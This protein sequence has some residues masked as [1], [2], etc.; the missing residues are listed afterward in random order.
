V[1]VKLKQRVSVTTSTACPS[2]QQIAAF[3]DGVLAG[4]ERDALQRHLDECPACFDLVATLAVHA[5]ADAARP[6]VDPRLRDAVVR[7]QQTPSKTALRLLPGLSAA[8]AI[9]L[10]AVWWIGPDGSRPAPSQPTAPAASDANPRATTRSADTEG[11]VT[12]QEPRDGAEIQGAQIVRWLGPPDATFYEIQITTIAGDVVLN[13][14][15][16][17]TEHEVRIELPPGG[18]PI[19]YLWVAAYLPEGRRITSNV[20]KL[21]LSPK[22]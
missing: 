13:R 9:L 11:P 5:D 17:G 20:V 15:V 22:R 12:V 10:A 2:E 21:R 19:H 4:D 1:S 3:V 16:A 6:A 7:K 8:A 14:R 18:D